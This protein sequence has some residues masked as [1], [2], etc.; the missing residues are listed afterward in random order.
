MVKL[1]YSYAMEYYSAKKEKNLVTRVITWMDLSVI[2]LSE[3]VNLKGFYY[4]INCCPP[5]THVIGPN[6]IPQNVTVGE[7]RSLKTLLR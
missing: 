7:N 6:P 3:K 4:G 5:Q 1:G 2:M